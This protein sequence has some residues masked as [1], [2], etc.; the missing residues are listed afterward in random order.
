MRKRGSVDSCAPF[1]NNLPVYG[2]DDI[3]NVAYVQALE[4]KVDR[5]R[6]LLGVPLL[7]AFALRTEYDMRVPGAPLFVQL[8][9]YVLFGNVSEVMFVGS[10]GGVNGDSCVDRNFA[11]MINASLPATF[12]TPRE[13]LLG[14]T[15]KFDCSMAPPPTPEWTHTYI[16]WSSESV[17][18]PEATSSSSPT[19][20][21]LSGFIGAAIGGAL[22]GGVCF[23]ISRRKRSNGYEALLSG[24]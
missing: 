13:F 19:W 17:A 14:G 22:V 8:N 15:E 24:E 3:V 12:L 9:K 20:I 18:T 10:R 6:A 5:V 23:F 1:N 21:V 7:G 16:P 2:V 4:F 11:A